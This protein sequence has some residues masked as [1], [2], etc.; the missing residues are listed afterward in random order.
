MGKI[1]LKWPLYFFI[2]LNIQ[3]LK[4]HHDLL[5]DFF[6]PLTVYDTRVSSAP[7]AW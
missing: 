2:V 5:R 6:C 7:P 3:T 1:T 4:Y